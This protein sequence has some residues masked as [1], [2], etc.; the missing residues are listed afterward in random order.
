MSNDWPA[1]CFGRSGY[2]V[3][4]PGRPY[5]GRRGDTALSQDL[6]RPEES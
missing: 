3:Q 5:S 1:M 6:V 4:H 2:G